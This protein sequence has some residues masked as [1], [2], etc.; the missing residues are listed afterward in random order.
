MA[1]WLASKREG[2]ASDW[3]M[4][5]DPRFWTLNFPRP[6]VATVVSTAP[7]GLRVEASFLRKTDLG[8]LIWD[9]VDALDHPLLAY[10]TDRDYAHTSLRFRWRSGGLIPLD[11]INGPTLTIE[12]RDEAGASHTWYVRLWNYAEGT[13]EDAV[14]TLDFSALDGGYALPADA[15]RVWP[16]AIERMFISFAPPGYDDAS[17]DPLPAETEGWFEMTEIATDGARAMLEIGDVV[18]PANGLA[19]ATGYDDQGIQTPARLIRAVRQL[20]YRGSVVHY[21]GMSHYFRLAANGGRY[22]AGQGGDPLNGPT[23]SWHRAFFA[24]CLAAGLS[25]MASLSYELLDQH[26][27]EDWK[28]R[29]LGGNP[30]LTGWDPPSTLLSPANSQAMAWLQTVSAAF[31]GS[32]AEVGAPVRFQIGEPWW[33]TFGD[34]RICLYDDAARAAFGGSPAAIPDMR[35]PLSPAQTA[36][37]DQAGALLAQSTADLVAAVRT[38]IA[39][40]PV[41]ALALVFTPTLLAPDMPELKRANLPTGWA[42]P[43]F[44]RLQVED[45][46]WLTAGADAHR[47][48]AH[49]E[50]DARLGYPA[51]EQDY[52]AG[53]VL[54]P[55]QRDQWLRI[56]AGIDEALTR[57]PHEVVVWALPQVARDGYV[58]LPPPPTSGADPMQAFDD[59]LYP[60]ALGRDATVVPEFST[61]VSVTASG[62]ERR[63]SLWSNAR[64][65]FDV[66]PGVRSEA[67]LGALIAFFRA[68]RGPARGFRL[69]D[70]SDFSSSGMVAAPGPLDQP[71]GTGDGIKAGFPL[72]KRYG[73][74][75]DAQV[76]RIT[77]PDFAT[78]LVSIDGALQVGNWTLAEHGVVTFDDAP[79]IGADIRAGFLFD[80]PVRFAEDSLEVSGAA[81]AA[82]EAPSVPVVEI[83]EAS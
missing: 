67:E 30:A 68:R 17:P 33:W 11:A 36:M 16:G 71:L 44:D 55:N 80:V 7:D 45:Y 6:M 56:D 83:R 25:P 42:A 18:M 19:I 77:R 38:A 64:L 70:P 34:G 53:F 13:G 2:Q 75:E 51:Q 5:F 60:L 28:Q 43:A 27:P 21:L 23:R 12:G 63:N 31:A 49:A 3:L 29:D 10:R 48:K 54:R 79:S 65:R 41:E 46:D 35:A 39:P 73:E 57:A 82:G 1:F 50:V 47:R 69:R 74:G 62:F 58:R 61:S 9:S 59:V 72:I 81:F 76:R 22:L 52:L 32:L 4:R 8:G 24:E 26:C 37:L 40:A 66:G 78:V 20:G 15:D 14:V